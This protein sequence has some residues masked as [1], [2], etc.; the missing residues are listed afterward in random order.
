MIKND[1]NKIIRK[2]EAIMK[3]QRKRGILVHI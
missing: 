1:P 3:K 2:K